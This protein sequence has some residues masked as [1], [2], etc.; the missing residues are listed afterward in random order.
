MAAQVSRVGS[1]AVRS[2]SLLSR[3]RPVVPIA[4][5]CIHGTG[6]NAVHTRVL[7]VFRPGAARR[8][9]ETETDR[10]PIEPRRW[11]SLLALPAPSAGGPATTRP[12]TAAG[13]R[14]GF[15]LCTSLVSAWTRRCLWLV[16]LLLLPEH[17]LLPSR[18]IE[19]I[20]SQTHP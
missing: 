17:H 1:Q 5:M 3:R 12:A 13:A 4:N 15:P 11:R 6:V 14:E 10:E 19:K 18:D 7:V 8:S 16:C 20:K 2:R 9:V